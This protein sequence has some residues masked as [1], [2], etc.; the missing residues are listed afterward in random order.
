MRWYQEITLL[1]GA[2]IPVSYLWTKV[3]TQLHLALAEAS[4]RNGAGRIGISFPGYGEKK[5]GTKL[6]LFAEEKE[7]LEALDTGAALER[8]L[9]YV[10][11]T[12][13]RKIP[14]GRLCGHA[15]YSRVQPDASV[16]R[17]ARRYAKRHEDMTYEAALVLLSS[18]GKDN[19]LPY[20]QLK[21]FSTG[22]K[23]S[24]FILRT[25]KEETKGTF[26]AYGF[27]PTATVP[28]F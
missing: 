23:F 28:E 26:S 1:P 8:L 24:L 10:H 9:D 11:L 14:E 18:K 13:I 6:R 4:R 16:E 5:L 19:A 3:F 2:E 7:T 20:I 25:E 22:E 27:S 17:K 12:G 15:V 21:S